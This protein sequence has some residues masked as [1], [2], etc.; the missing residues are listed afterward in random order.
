MLENFVPSVAILYVHPLNP[1]Q[2]ANCFIIDFYFIIGYPLDRISMKPSSTWNIFSLSNSILPEPNFCKSSIFIKLAG[3]TS[4]F[5]SIANTGSKIYFLPISN[6]SFLMAHSFSNCTSFMPR[7][8]PLGN[9]PPPRPGGNCALT[10]PSNKNGKSNFISLK[11]DFSNFKLV[12]RV[13][14]FDALDINY[15]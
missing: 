15:S 11:L 4:V 8:A 14:D 9:P 2:M 1:I 10:G 6:N 13:A 3:G 12:V 5:I 7:P